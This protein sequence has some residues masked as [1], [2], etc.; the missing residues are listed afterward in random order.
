MRASDD[1]HTAL[2][3]GSQID[4]PPCEAFQLGDCFANAVAM[5]EAMPPKGMTWRPDVLYADIPW[6]AGWEVFL[7]RSKAAD[8][9]SVLH[10][11][12]S[13]RGFV[14]TVDRMARAHA[15][16]GGLAVIVG[17][18]ST[19]GGRWMHS[20][21][22]FPCI[23]NGAPAAAAVYSASV[24]DWLREACPRRVHDTAEVLQLLAAHC[25]GV[26]DP[27]CGYGRTGR[28]FQQAGKRWWLTDINP[29]CIGRI[30]QAAADWPRLKP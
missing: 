21:L 30:A 26:W 5:E 22:T 8:P 12:E 3:G 1:Y 25:R 29:V 11:S 6:Q 19:V 24:P 17:S 10:V 7:D 28:V 23:L 16:F 9:G 20:D 13:Y 14:A 27:C 2:V 4:S 18:T 15:I